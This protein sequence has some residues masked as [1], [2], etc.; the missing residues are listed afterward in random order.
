MISRIL[1]LFDEVTHEITQ[2]LGASPVTG[3]G[4]RCKTF[5][6]FFFDPKGKSSF[7]HCDN[8]LCYL[9]SAM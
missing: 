6:Q 5:L 3:F 4:S 9:I 7:S 8:P 1:L 2:E